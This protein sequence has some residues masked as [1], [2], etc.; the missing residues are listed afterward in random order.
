MLLT[1][2]R[3]R[4]RQLRRVHADRP[5]HLRDRHQPRQAGP[6]PR[7]RE[8]PHGGAARRRRRDGRRRGRLRG[9]RRGRR[10]VHGHLGGR[11]GRRRRR[12]PRRRDRAAAAQ[13]RHRRR[14]RVRA[15]T[16]ARSSPP[17]TATRWPA[18]SVRASR[19]GPRWWSTAARPTC[20]RTGFFLG[21]T[22][23]DHVSPEMT[24]YTDEIFGPVLAVVRADT[25]E[26]A[27]ELVNANQYAN[28]VAI[29]TRDGGAARQFQFDI[30]VGMVGIN[31]P[32]PVPVAYVLLRRLEVLVVRRHP[33]VRPGGHQLLHPRQGGHLALAGPV[34]L[35]RRPGLP[36]DPLSGP[37]RRRASRAGRR[38]T[39]AGLARLARP[40]GSAAG[41]RSW[42]DD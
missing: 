1:D 19:P 9:V 39:G 15:P 40:A 29:F 34:D 25:Y 17:S 4:R 3:R 11:R 2:P 22:L 37:S 33:H 14:R 30:E 41:A 36:P 10:A 20:P 13:A 8:E 16:W 38:G 24:V 31:V 12:R 23:L 26:D 35:G 5:L 28:G 21:T 6:G 27:V 18:T 32:I 7:G 42:R